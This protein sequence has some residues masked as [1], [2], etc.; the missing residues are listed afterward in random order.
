[1]TK[2]VDYETSFITL[3]EF[4]AIT[5]S[6]DHGKLHFNTNHYEYP[7]NIWFGAVWKNNQL[8]GKFEREEEN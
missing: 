4:P 7:W 8:A 6:E 3:A 1:M 2:L 5:W